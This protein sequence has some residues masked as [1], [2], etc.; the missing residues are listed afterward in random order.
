MQNTE[1]ILHNEK[2]WHEKLG[3]HGKPECSFQAMAIINISF[4][5]ILNQENMNQKH[6]QVKKLFH[7]LRKCNYYKT[8]Q[9]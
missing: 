2:C 5:Y 6:F 3:N 8:F 9:I 1:G 4:C 7:F